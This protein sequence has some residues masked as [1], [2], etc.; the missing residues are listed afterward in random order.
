[1]N[2]KP[3]GWCDV[4]AIFTAIQLSNFL[5]SYFDAGEN[6]ILKKFYAFLSYKPTKAL[7][8]ELLNLFNTTGRNVQTH[9]NHGKLVINFDCAQSMSNGERDILSFISNLTK[10]K[11]RL[12]ASRNFGNW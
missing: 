4:D 2:S 12:K 3:D 10:L 11:L 1:M 6:D 7:I 5:K 8:D 9:E